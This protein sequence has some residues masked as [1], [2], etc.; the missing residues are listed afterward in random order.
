VHSHF[1]GVVCQHLMTV[2][3][4][5][6]ESCVLER[7]DDGPFE[8]DRLLLGIGVRQCSFL[9]KPVAKRQGP[10]PALPLPQG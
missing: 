2:V 5:H 8:Q 3:G 9:L 10:S 1:A 4:L 6:T 7:L